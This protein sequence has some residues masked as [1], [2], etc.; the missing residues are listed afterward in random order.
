[1]IPLPI[2]TERL[3]IRAWTDDDVPRLSEIFGD[4]EVMRY[5]SLGDWTVPGL[6]EKYRRDYERHGYGLWALCEADGRVIGDV[7]FRP[8]EEVGDPE[9][10][11]TLAREAWHHGYASEAGRACVDALFAHTDH[12]RVLALVDT[13][14]EAS[15]RTAERIGFHVIDTVEQP[16][17]PH[18]LLELTRP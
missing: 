3:L 9:L 15:R 12:D 13:R 2:E 14:N 16:D 1:V 5:V 10:G 11:Y 4:P 6:L 7:G 17:H 18:W 8:Y